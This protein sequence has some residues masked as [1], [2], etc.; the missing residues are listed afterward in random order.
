MDNCIFC[1]IIGGQIPSTKLYDDQDMII[2]KDISPQAKIHL[3][4]I[5]KE[6]YPNILEMSESQAATLAKCLKTLSTLVNTLGLEKGQ[7]FQAVPRDK[8]AHT[9]VRPRAGQVTQ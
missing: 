5:P 3:L 2:I 4:L 6:H 8:A 9:R 7:L 1:K